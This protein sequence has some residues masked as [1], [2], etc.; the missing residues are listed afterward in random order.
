MNRQKRNT[1]RFLI[2]FLLGGFANLFSRGENVVGNLMASLNYTI[3]VGLLL[4]WIDSVRVRLLP[5]V[6]K[7]YIVT[8][9]FLLL[10]HMLLRIFNYRFAVEPAAIRYAGYAYWI[11]QMVVPALFLMT[12]IGFRREEPKEKPVRERCLPAGKRFPTNGITSTAEAPWP[13]AG[14]SSRRNGI[15]SILR[16]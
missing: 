2:L 15:T 1:I 12:C 10:L 7:T 9:G 3:F 6:A 11:P 8:A 5:S 13:P 4:F 14:S 16:V